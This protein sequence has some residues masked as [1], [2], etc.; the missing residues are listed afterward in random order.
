MTVKTNI[1]LSANISV[2]WETTAM[3][4]KHYRKMSS[5]QLDYHTN[6]VFVGKQACI[7]Q[8][9]SKIANVWPFPNEFPWM[10]MHPLL[11]L[12]CHMNENSQRRP[13]SLLLVMYFSYLQW[14]TISYLHLLCVKLAFW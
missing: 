12:H 6:M 2:I 10:E 1:S 5:T 9:S 11:M 3:G 4:D 7:I 8:R 13:T 14:R